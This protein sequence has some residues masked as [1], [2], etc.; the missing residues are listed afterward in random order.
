MSPLR[1]ELQRADIVSVRADVCVSSIHRSKD[2]TKG[3]LAKRILKCG[4]NSIQEE[5]LKRDPGKELKIGQVEAVSSGKLQ[6]FKDLNFICLCTYRPGNEQ[7]LLQSLL[8]CLELAA[9]KNHKSVAFPALGIGHGYPAE[10]VAACL[11]EA[12]TLH[13]YQFP[14]TSLDVVYVVLLD[15]DV[16]VIK[17]FLL[18]CAKGTTDLEVD[19]TSQLPINSGTTQKTATCPPKM[20]T[21]MGQK[22]KA[23]QANQPIRVNSLFA[24]ISSLFKGFG[25]SANVG[26]FTFN[27]KPTISNRIAGFQVS[28]GLN[29]SF[30][31][32]F[33]PPSLHPLWKSIT[34]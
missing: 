27:V 31:D 2:L 10:K 16:D 4:G 8:E 3:P 14:K 22:K 21:V 33:I 17:T 1:L 7:I 23:K 19:T 13:N 28:F 24:S 32:T 18:M 25:Y 20:P 29:I 6:N 5:L 12:A 15:H 11:I 26:L 30:I 34:S 9:V